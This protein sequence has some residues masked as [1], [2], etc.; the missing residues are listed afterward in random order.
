M[1]LTAFL[2][3]AITSW[4]QALI[5]LC[6]LVLEFNASQQGVQDAMLAMQVWGMCTHHCLRPQPLFARL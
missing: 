1:S 2:V 5:C 4:L 6:I 3:E